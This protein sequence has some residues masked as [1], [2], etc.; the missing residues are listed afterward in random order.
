MVKMDEIKIVKYQESDYSK[1]SD[2]ARVAFHS[3]YILSDEKFLDWQ[4]LSPGS[5][6]LLAKK[7]S[8]T[9][10]LG[11][12]HE[13]IIGFFG[14]KDFPYKIYGET[15]NA[16][17]IMNLFV[18]EKY[19]MA[20]VGPKLVEAVFDT[21]NY[22]LSSSLNEASRKLYWHYRPSFKEVGDL[23]RYMAV[24]GGHKLMEGFNYREIASQEPR[25][26]NRN[27]S[28]V[29][30]PRP[31]DGTRN[32]INFT[33]L[34]KA[35]AR[36]DNF[37]ARV[38]GRYL[39]TIERYSEY[40]NW[41]FFKHPIFEYKS[42]VAEKGGSVYGFLFW[43]MEEVDD[44]KIARI[45]D[46]VA[47]ESSEASLLREFLER[48]KEAG[49]YAADFMFSGDFYKNS[50]EAVGFFDTKGTDFDKFPIRF[51]PLSYSK[52][53]INIAYDI[54]APLADCYLTKADSDQDRPN[55]H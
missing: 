19:R 40:L 22:I 11:T 18:A 31:E 7:G 13:E 5:A 35:D 10:S 29:R 43:R 49:A 4:Y 47:E 38:R 3:K 17:V 26:D 8:P 53:V 41:R 23:N 30:L 25:N 36:F 21:E 45:I 9:T 37:W 27:Y 55:P 2:F 14:Y 20:G 6:L 34:E 50:L 52:F 1:F 12:K 42:I 24:L 51:N 44:F 46:F 16:R 48:A 28:N 33:S 39:A 54:P 32:D 15:K